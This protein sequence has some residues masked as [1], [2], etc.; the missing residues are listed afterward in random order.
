MDGRGRSI[1]GRGVD[2]EALTVGGQ[3]I[4]PAVGIANDRC[5]C[6]KEQ[7][8]DDWKPAACICDDTLMS[9]DYGT[10]MARSDASNVIASAFSGAF[11][12]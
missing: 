6:A 8:R 1:R 5:L 11:S 7:G 9:A 2:Q 12:A 3:G 10:G 4:G